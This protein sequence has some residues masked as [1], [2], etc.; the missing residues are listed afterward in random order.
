MRESDFGHPQQTSAMRTLLSQP[1][2][3][4]FLVG[5]A[6]GLLMYDSDTG[7]GIAVA[8]VIVA[9]L[10][11][12]LGNRRWVIEVFS[13]IPSMAGGSLCSLTTVWKRDPTA[14]NL[15][16][17]ELVMLSVMVTGFLLLSGGVGALVRRYLLNKTP[18][19]QP[20]ASLSDWIVPFATVVGIVGYVLLRG[21]MAGTK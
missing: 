21:A 1:G 7:A 2:S 18:E 14:H 12:G 3:I 9:G 8:G 20:P 4:G 19:P 11:L 6:A 10:L 17:F 13:L 5:F 16:P 15:W